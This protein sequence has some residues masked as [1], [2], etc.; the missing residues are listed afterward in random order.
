MSTN[1]RA[2]TTTVASKAN[3]IKTVRTI[4]R[5]LPIPAPPWVLFQNGTIVFISRSTTQRDVAIRHAIK[6]LGNFDSCTGRFD[7]E[8]YTRHLHTYGAY[9]TAYHSFRSLLSIL[10][11]LPSLRIQTD[12]VSS[13]KDVGNKCVLNVVHDYHSPIVIAT[14]F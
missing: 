12:T 10:P 4:C 5:Q 2:T 11:E 14:S 9:A 3:L 6:A 1:T 13:L 7:S 8:F